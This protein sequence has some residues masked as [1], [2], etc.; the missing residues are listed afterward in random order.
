MS[1]AWPLLGDSPA[2]RTN[3][4]GF[5]LQIAREQGDVARFHI[6]RRE[7]F[8]LSHPDHVNAV[9]VRRADEFGKGRLMQRARRLLGNGLLTSEG[10]F[11]RAQRRQIQPAFTH[12]QIRRAVASVP[13]VAAARAAR[14]TASPIRADNEMDALAMTVVSGAL[15]GTEI[16]VRLP[17][18]QASLHTLVRWAPLLMLPGG[19]LLERIR[20]PVIGGVGRAL[21][22]VER[23]IAEC[24]E[25]GAPDAPLLAALRRSASD[26]MP[27]AQMR[28]E[29]MTNF[30][31]GHDT[32]AATLTW[33]WLLLAEHPGVRVRL[34][35]ELEERLGDADPTVDDIPRL[36]WTAAVIDEALRLFPPIGR[37]GRRPISDVVLPDV[38]LPADS[39]VFISPY[40][41]HRDARW[42]P[43]PD[44]FDPARWGAEASGRPRFAWIPFGAGPRSCIGEH[45][46]RTMLVLTVATIA[47]RWQL[48]PIKPGLPAPRSLLTVKPRRAVWMAVRPHPRYAQASA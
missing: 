10:D 29:V 21:A 15:L 35:A 44:R 23:A 41:I 39:T 32:T 14:W 12:D 27:A 4:T 31:A 37:I 2:F 38:T 34:Q 26:T 19:R 28:D 1:G 3:A 43:E 8:L 13:A 40:V 6:G 7:A 22:T 20:A 46:A 45:F 18:L 42:Y 16:D 5:L 25:R 36:T 48:D 33:V 47:R 9:L 24:I 17:A 30:L 11:H